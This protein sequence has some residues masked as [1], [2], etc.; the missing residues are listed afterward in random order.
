[1]V[2]SPNYDL[3]RYV[4]PSDQKLQYV[5]NDLTSSE[6]YRMICMVD[7]IHTNVNGIFNSHCV[8]YDREIPECILDPNSETLRRYIGPDGYPGGMHLSDVTKGYNIP[9]P[10]KKYNDPTLSLD[11][12][13]VD[14]IKL[15]LKV[16]SNI[17]NNIEF[18]YVGTFDSLPDHILHMINTHSNITCLRNDNLFGGFGKN[19]LISAT[20]CYKL[21]ANTEL[22]NGF[23]ILKD[24]FQNHILVPPTTP[25]SYNPIYEG[26]QY[27]SMGMCLLYQNYLGYMIVYGLPF[28]KI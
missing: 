7:G 24:K 15:K 5:T 22:P 26:H 17:D 25:T 1:M 27:S 6:W 18:R 23:E 9:N 16:I 11:S 13:S 2:K 4:R 20:I 3:Y 12:I 14:E 21:P 10:K 19:E 8:E 28:I